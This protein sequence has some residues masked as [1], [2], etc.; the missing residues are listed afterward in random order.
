[1][2]LLQ[3]SNVRPTLCVVVRRY[4]P[5]RPMSQIPVVWPRLW[6]ACL[7]SCLR[8]PPQLAVNNFLNFE[9]WNCC[10]F[11]SLEAGGGIAFLLPLACM[12]KVP[13][14]LVSQCLHC[15]SCVPHLSA[16]L[17]PTLSPSLSSTVCCAV[18]PTWNLGL[19]VSH[20][21]SVSPTVSP[22]LSPLCLPPGNLE[23]SLGLC[24]PPCLLLVSHLV[25]CLSPILSPILSPT[26]CRRCFPSGTLFAASS[27]TVLRIVC[28]CTV[29]RDVKLLHIILY[30]IIYC[31]GSPGSRGGR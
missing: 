6:L 27:R 1:M 26:V 30:Y 13:G 10:G 9:S 17:S 28:V 8:P 22:S 7:P 2:R 3:F 21:V 23:P 29:C 14:T 20:C 15:V 16:A 18:S 31:W 12:R 24:F 5:P 19:L 25:S 4:F 11:Q